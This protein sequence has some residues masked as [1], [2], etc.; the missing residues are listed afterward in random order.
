MGSKQEDELPLPSG[1]VGGGA[2]GTGWD[3]GE[4]STWWELQED[5]GIYR[6]PTVC[7]SPDTSFQVQG[8]NKFAMERTPPPAAL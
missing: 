6:A 4:G 8:K 5:C 3:G 7:R 2:G 1:G